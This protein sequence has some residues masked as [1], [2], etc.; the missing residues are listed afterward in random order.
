MNDIISL[1]KVSVHTGR[2][3]FVEPGPV[4]EGTLGLSE[5]TQRHHCHCGAGKA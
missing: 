2:T 4:R 1:P 5:K 3:T